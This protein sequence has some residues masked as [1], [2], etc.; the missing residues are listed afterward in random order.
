M[1]GTS[2]RL[3]PVIK[4]I[5]D[6]NLACSYCYQAGRLRPGQRMSRATLERVLLEVK[7]LTRGPI[8]LLWYGG[9]PTLV[10]LDC[11]RSAVDFAET[12]L[13]DR[14]V[15]H[16]IQTNAVLIDA[17]WSGF[18][19]ERRFGVSL[20]LDG[21]EQLHDAR[22]PFRRGGG[23][24]ASVVSGVDCLRE[25]GL[26]PRA[27]CVIDQQTIAFP[28]ELV[29]YF[30]ALQ[31]A[32]VDFAPGLRL[33]KGRPQ[34]L[35]GGL[36]FGRFMV[37]AL[38]RW[39]ALGRADFKIRGLSGLLRALSGQASGYCKLESSCSTYV[40]FSH[41]GDVYPCDEFAACVGNVHLSNLEDLLDSPRTQAMYSAWQSTPAACS[42]CR[43]RDL[44]RG[45]CPFERQM[46]GGVD[47]PSLLCEGL[48]LLYQRA[49]AALTCGG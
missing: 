35:V 17:D 24:H 5:E 6:C 34:A 23:S 3:S 45:G 42:D 47:R 44:C 25:A 49:E 48:K 36:E 39:L 7:R 14:P 38:D 22:R 18:L 32:E 20:S 10:G 11:F 15:R 26:S 30:A 41:N 4:L 31:L 27:S 29:D 33:V 37:R 40:T 16:S 19:A 21:P 28:E 46:A 8:Q 13:G 1:S 43:W 12:V 9:E 2:R